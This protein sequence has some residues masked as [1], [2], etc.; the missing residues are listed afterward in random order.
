MPDDIAVDYTAQSL[1]LSEGD[2]QHLLHMDRQKG[3]FLL[4]QNQEN[5]ALALSMDEME[6]VR[7]IFANDIK[8]LIAAGGKFAS[9]PKD[10]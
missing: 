4:K 5:I 7:A 3:H 10:Y 6:D 9:L 2:V 8:N 1:G